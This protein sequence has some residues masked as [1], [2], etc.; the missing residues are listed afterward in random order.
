MIVQ[1]NVE[2]I[3][4]TI[5]AGRVARLDIRV[6]VGDNCAIL[7]FSQRHLT[8]HSWIYLRNFWFLKVK[9]K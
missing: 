5:A 6:G 3:V 9:V 4:Y 2:T 8:G 7:D 1:A